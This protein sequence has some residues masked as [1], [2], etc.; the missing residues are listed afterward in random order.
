MYANGVGAAHQVVLVGAV[1]GALAVGVV[2]VEVHARRPRVESR[3]HGLPHHQ[4]AGPVPGHGGARR[5]DLGRAVL[6]VG[7]VDVEPG[8]VG[9]DDVGQ[10]RVLESSVSWL[11]W[12]LAAAH[13]EAAGV[14]Q[15]RLVGVV[16]AGPGRPDAPRV[17]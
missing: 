13:V 8:A 11:G 6:G 17:A 4:L 2:L 3:A 9:E 10:G 14:A 7:V 1:G 5:G 16:P 12:R 15:R